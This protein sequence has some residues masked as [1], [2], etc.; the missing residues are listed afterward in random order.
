LANSFFPSINHYFLRFL[1]EADIRADLV[2]GTGIGIGEIW[3]TWGREIEVTESIVIDAVEVEE[4]S[5]ISSVRVWAYRRDFVIE[6]IGEFDASI[7]RLND[8]HTES[9]EILVN[10]EEN[11]N[12]GS[13]VERASA[14]KFSSI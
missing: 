12:I 7:G 1:T 9:S 14:V 11:T 4:E 2:I 10:T 13:L 3:G 6:I 5:A 8:V